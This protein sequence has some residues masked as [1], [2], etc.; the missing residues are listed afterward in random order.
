MTRT[1]FLALSLLASSLGS[2]PLHAQESQDLVELLGERARAAST[3]EITGLWAE[4]QR[5]EE[6]LMSG[7]DNGVSQTLDALLGQASELG[8]RGTLLMVAV[9]IGGDAPDYA[10]LTQALRPLFESQDQSVRG[11]AASLFESRDFAQI[12][13]DDLRAVIEELLDGAQNIENAPETRLAFAVAA[14]AQGGGSVQREARKVMRSFLDSSSP[15]L[16]GAGA[17]ALAQIGDLETARGEL[18]RL[19]SNPGPEGRLAAAH[20]RNEELKVFFESKQ[21]SLRERLASANEAGA[22][23]EDLEAIDEMIEL[24]TDR[25]IEGDLQTREELINAALDGI[26]HSLDQHSAYMSTE[27]FSSFQQDLQGEYGG[28][29]A[30]VGIDQND[31]LFTITQPIYSGP[32]YKA[33]L[34]TDDKIVKIDDW[35]THVHGI[36]K[37]QDDII[38]RLKGKP[39]TDLKLYI[40]RR[41]DD[42]GKIER[43]TEEMAV[44]VTRGFITI[45][46]VKHELLPGDVGLVQLDQFSNIASREVKK[47]I[48]ELKEQGAEAIVLDLRNNPGGLLSEARRVADLFLPK[49]LRVVTT[50]SRLEEPEHLVTRSNPVVPEDMPVVVLINRFSASASEIV[51][52]AL[53]DHEFATLVGQRSFGKGSVQHLVRVGEDDKYNDENHNRQRDNW[54]P[55][56]KDLNENGEFDYAPRAKLTIAR[57]L[58]PSTRSIHR[59]L[60]EEGNIISLGGVSPEFFVQPKR[61]DAWRLQALNDLIEAG[62]VREWVREGWADH[63]ELF[64]QL[65]FTDGKDPSRYPGFDDLYDGLATPLPKEDVRYLVRREVRRL[66]QDKRGSAFPRGDFEED[67]QLQKAIQIALEGLN[68]KADDIVQYRETFEVGEDLTGRAVARADEAARMGRRR[69]VDH[70][71]S[72]IAEARRDNRTLSQEQLEELQEILSRMDK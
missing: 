65:A 9:R 61:W 54:E 31:N 55:L 67:L 10:L 33:D 62:E 23:P 30:Y 13:L 44:T 17:L 51:A 24:V 37:D 48:K 28:I 45:P 47:S 6:L 3:L 18:E 22:P 5:I 41:G 16:R 15:E 50:E 56:T 58:L 27:V 69:D 29:G 34:R 35:P 42:P 52:G 36:S 38:R 53:Q 57:Y 64:S 71:L 25:H 46:T 63:E 20:L 26:L 39:N 66:A 72:L 49:G 1:R 8:E 60:D 32:A 7:E 14:H 40:W 2:L 59:E 12:D 68:R 43:P 4:A 19:A 70:A 21:R 11:A